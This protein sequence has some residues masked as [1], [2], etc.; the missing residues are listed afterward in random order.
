MAAHRKA[1]AIEFSRQLPLPDCM[2]PDAVSKCR[3]LQGGHIASW[4]RGWSSSRGDRLMCLRGL[5]TSNNFMRS[6]I[7]R[8]QNSARVLD[9]GL[10]HRRHMS[11]PVHVNADTDE[12]PE[13]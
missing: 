11:Q 6:D 4:L 12:G 1:S 10:R 9:E 7:A 13:R 2:W 3:R 8:L 5:S